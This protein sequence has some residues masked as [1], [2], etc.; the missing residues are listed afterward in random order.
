MKKHLHL[1]LFDTVILNMLLA[2]CCSLASCKKDINI[3]LGNNE[4]H[5]IVEAYINNLMPQY[6]YVLLTQ[7]INYFDQQFTGIAVS[8][9]QVTVTEGEL[10]P[11]NTVSWNRATKMLL[12]QSADERIPAD[13]RKGFYVDQKTIDVLSVGGRGF[14]AEPGKYYLLEISWEGRNYSAITSLPGLVTLDSLSAGFPYADI[15]DSGKQKAAVTAHYK[16]PDTLGNRQLYYWRHTKN[17]DSFGWGAL[18]SNRHSNGEDDLVNGQ[19]VKMTQPTG[20]VNG[21]TVDYYLVSVTRPVY[22]FWESF[23]NA[24]NNAGPFATPIKLTGNLK[25]PNVTGCF[26]GFTVST[27]SIVV[28]I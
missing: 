14:S 1:R 19:S 16:D 5:L 21:E 17:R 25:G 23:N 12:E 9:A 7:S 10:Q 28:K 24:R 20:F 11:D 2:L 22:N 18:T 3:T 13:Y 4:P 15:E 6:N 8:N 27:Q 26:S